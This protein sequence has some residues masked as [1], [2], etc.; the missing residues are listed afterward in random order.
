[1][2]RPIHGMIAR[3]APGSRKSPKTRLR[4]GMPRI[5]VLLRREGWFITHKKTYRIY[6][7]EGLN[8][9]RRRPRVRVADMHRESRPV[10]TNL[11]EVWCMDFVADELF[12]GRRIRYVTG[13][14]NLSWEA[15]ATSVDHSLKGDAIVGAVEMIVQMLGLPKSIQVD[16]G[17]EFI[18]MALDQW[19]YDHGVQLDFSRTGKPT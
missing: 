9:R 7:E 16:N 18:T 12:N 11:D 17:S 10:V 3:S 1:M 15:L 19:L 5:L 13:V 14:N 6:C 8:L 4:Y 2:T